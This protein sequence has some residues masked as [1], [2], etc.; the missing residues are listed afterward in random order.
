MTAFNDLTKVETISFK[1]IIKGWVGPDSFKLFKNQKEPSIK[2]CERA[3]TSFIE[4]FSQ[5]NLSVV[6]VEDS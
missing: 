3:M 4:I 2:N 5:R 6:G 1:D